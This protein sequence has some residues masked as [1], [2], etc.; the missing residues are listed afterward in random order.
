MMAVGMEVFR[1]HFST[2]RDQYVLIGGMACELLL[3]EAGER[4]RPTK[5]AMKMTINKIKI[6][7]TTILNSYC[8]SP[9]KVFPLSSVIFTLTKVPISEEGALNAIFSCCSV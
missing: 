4:F 1:A 9:R 8:N 2:Y 6:K 7:V 3:N 5:K